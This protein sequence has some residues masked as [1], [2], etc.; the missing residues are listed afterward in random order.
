MIR[1]I[2][3]YKAG[4]EAPPGTYWNAR[5]GEYVTVATGRLPGGE[6]IYIRAHPLLILALG[7]IMG[8]MFVMF[9]PLAVP[10]LI[11]RAVV[12]RVRGSARSRGRFFRRAGGRPC[13]TEAGVEERRLVGSSR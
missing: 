6:G 5:S 13:P 4:Q 9:L 8:L 7:S 11:G 3:P 2:R 12:E 10:L 1:T